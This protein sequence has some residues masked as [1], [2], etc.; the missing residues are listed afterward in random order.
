MTFKRK[1]VNHTGVAMA[2]DLARA[3]DPVLLARD[4]GVE[5]DPWQAKLLRSNAP[6]VLGLCARQTG[7]STTTSLIA[8]A[9]AL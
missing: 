7:K 9:T 5:P 6:R 1:S 3:L 2:L 8:M 4:C